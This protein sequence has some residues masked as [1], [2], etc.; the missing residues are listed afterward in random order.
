MIHPDKR[1]RG[2]IRSIIKL[3]IKQGFNMGLHKLWLMI[4]EDNIKGKKLY[5]S[6][7]FTL[8]ATLIDEY[9]DPL[10]GQFVNMIRLY[11]LNTQELQ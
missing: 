3:I 7:G 6:L 4:R 9:I 11:I 2:Y 8:E 5:I 1:G 10:T